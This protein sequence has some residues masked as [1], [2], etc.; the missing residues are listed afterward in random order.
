MP[1]KLNLRALNKMVGDG[2]TTEI[3]WYKGKYHILH[4][5]KNGVPVPLFISK[6][7]KEI[8]DEIRREG[9]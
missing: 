9:Y 7:A 3:T 5:C 4:I 2:E 1:A 8:A 6:D